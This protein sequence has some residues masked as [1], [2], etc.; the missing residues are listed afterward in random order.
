[1]FCVE[2]GRE[3]KLYRGLCSQCYLAKNVFVEIP[4]NI[5]VQICGSCGARKKGKV[6]ILDEEDQLKSNIIE[7]SKCHEDVTD[8]DVQI[9][10]E[11]QDESNINLRV[12][13]N[14]NALSLNIQKEHEIMLHIKHVVCSECSK[15]HGGYWEAKVQLRGAKRGLSEEDFK[16]AMELV[17]L[18]V[19]ERER[20][21]KGAFLTKVEKIH[22]GIDF[23]LGSKNIGKNI[24]KKLANEFGGEIKESHKLVGRKAGKDVHRTTYSVRASDLRKG[25]F[26][27]IK[28]N[29]MRVK[30]ISANKVV[31][32]ELATLKNIPFKSGELKEARVLGGDDI[33][34]EMVVV[35][36][37]E[38]EIQVLD[39][40][41]LKTVDVLLP[42][43]FTIDGETAYVV[44]CEAGYFLVEG[45]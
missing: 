22:N 39:P 9:A 31:L 4:K 23:Y 30:N 27:L 24:A 12:T 44:K 28:K 17:D 45:E 40:D 35:S 19:A 26:V 36:R 29:V 42:K 6:W 16:T 33:V 34:K 13:T 8:F 7:N 43:G 15:L 18:M 10:S 14:A 32:R 41:T 21:E 5:D 1:M 2:C 38:S 20:K 3:G 25:D 37:S 11:S